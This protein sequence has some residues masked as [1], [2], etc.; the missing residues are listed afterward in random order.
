M[1]I[2]EKAGKLKSFRSGFFEIMRGGF[3]DAG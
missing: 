3:G 2:K 1:S